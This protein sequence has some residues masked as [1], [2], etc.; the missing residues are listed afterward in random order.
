MTLTDRALRLH[1]DA[2]AGKIA[3]AITKPCATPDDLSLA[4]SPGVAAP[5][6]AIA[7]DPEA[8]YRYTGRGNLV[9]VITNGTAVL[10]LGNI[11]PAAAKPV[12]EGKAVLFKRFAGIDAFD[13]ELAATRVEDVVAACTMLEPTF[14][15]INLEDIKAPECFAIERLLRERL[16]IPV[17][18]DDQHGTAVVVAAALLS[19][20]AC[21]GRQM[22]D[23]RVVLSGAG[24]GAL[25]CAAHL[26]RLGLA[27]E[28]LLVC[29]SQGVIYQGRP[30]VNESKAPFARRTAART[31]TDALVGADV[32]LGLSVGNSVPSAALADMTANPIVFGL[33]NPDPDIPYG[34]IRATRPDAVVATGRSDY[35][36]Q[37]NNVL[38]FPGIFRGAL[39][40][41]SSCINDAMLMAATTAIGA[42]AQEPVPASVRALYP[43]ESLIWGRDYLIPKA[44]DPRV[45][46]RVATAVAAAAMKSGV[47]RQPVDLVAYPGEVA[48]RVEQ[49]D[50][51]ALTR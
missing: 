36:N 5:C 6:L 11:G 26:K 40:T 20:L 34:E 23:I 17:F 46:V 4:Y 12:M 27:D 24:A 47:A 9:A 7:E 10:G 15:G 2:P 51:P 45:V 44:F 19:A 22:S 33:A 31:V 16:S 43:G 8:V 1:E 38:G 29:D 32:F 50:V 37:V 48:A 3:T 21:T 28:Q 42:V 18:H 35:P 13:I 49:P 39:D 25:A 14:G 41:R 30:G